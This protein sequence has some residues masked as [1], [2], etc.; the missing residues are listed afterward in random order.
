MPRD[1]K[2][3]DELVRQE[4][5][6]N[7]FGDKETSDSIVPTD[8]P[9]DYI[10]PGMLMSAGKKIA[11]NPETFKALKALVTDVPELVSNEVGSVGRNVK[12]WNVGKGIK[13]V[14]NPSRPIG[15]VTNDLRPSTPYSAGKVIVKDIPRE[16][17]FGNIINKLDHSPIV[18]NT[19]LAAESEALPIGNVTTQELPKELP[20]G[21]TIHKVDPIQT[22]TNTEFAKE[23]KNSTPPLGKAINDIK[24]SAP[25]SPPEGKLIIDKDELVQKFKK[26]TE[27]LKKE[28]KL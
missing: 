25:Y 5:L 23:A 11:S 13:L 26:L 4:F 28:G 10:A 6:Q 3:T 9:I 8:S 27:K 21:E 20:V 19:E 17:R 24:Q 14:D 15:S 1:I 2:P 18:T 12:P 7:L 16:T 22:I